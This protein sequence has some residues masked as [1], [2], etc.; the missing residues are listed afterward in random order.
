MLLIGKLKRVRD[1]GLGI[2][3]NGTVNGAS[4]PRNVSM[5]E[6][7]ALLLKHCELV[8]ESLSRLNWT[9]GDISWTIKP[10]R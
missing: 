9:L 6:K 7:G 8:R 2:H 4:K 5:P 10:A 3:N 1:S